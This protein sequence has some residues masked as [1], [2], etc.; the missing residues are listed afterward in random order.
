MG[1]GLKSPEKLV[2]SSRI[3]RLLKYFLNPA[4][5]YVIFMTILSHPFEDQL[6]R[7][8]TCV[9]IV[10]NPHVMIYLTFIWM[11]RHM[12][13]SYCWKKWDEN[14]Y[15]VPT[16]LHLHLYEIVLNQFY[17][18]TYGSYHENW[19][20]YL[21]KMQATSERIWTHYESHYLKC[22]HVSLVVL[23]N[24]LHQDVPQFIPLFRVRK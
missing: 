2:K 3:D 20:D 12:Y 11:P 14:N 19:K 8:H 4:A 6:Y 15:E 18:P 16:L 24:C 22:S 1:K 13:R 10:I 23:D 5:S 17:L 7:R 9:T 21:V